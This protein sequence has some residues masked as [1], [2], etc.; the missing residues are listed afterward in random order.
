MNFSIYFFYTPFLN[1][2]ILILFV[3]S[4]H[5]TIIKMKQNNTTQGISCHTHI[6]TEIFLLVR[7]SLQRDKDKYHLK[8]FFAEGSTETCVVIKGEFFFLYIVF[9]KRNNPPSKNLAKTVFQ[10]E[11]CASDSVVEN[12][13][14]FVLDIKNQYNIF[15]VLYFKTNVYRKLF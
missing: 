14:T 10:Q 1:C 13:L 2:E 4:I 12:Q 11:F 8:N 6:S 3:L 15:S 5:R 9:W 7:I